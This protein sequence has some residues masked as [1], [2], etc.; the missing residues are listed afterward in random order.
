MYHRILN[1]LIATQNHQ[2]EAFLRGAPPVER[3]SYQFFCHPDVDEVDLKGYGVIVLDF[4]NVK[5]ISLEKIL[6]AKDEQA[7]VVGCFSAD[8]FPTLEEH[9][10]LFDQIWIK[11]FVEEK[12][13]SCFS[14]IMKGLKEQEDSI[15]T[16]KYLDTLID[17]LPDLIWV[18]DAM[19]AHLKVNN[20][21]CRAVNKTKAQI[22]GR[23]HY[24][25]WDLEPDE[26]AQGEYICLESEEIVL[27]KKETCLFDET[28]KCGN[29]LRKFKTYKSPIFDTDGSVIGTVGFAHDV[30]D[31]QNLLIELNILIESL[32]FAV[33]ITDKDR[34]IT[35]V[36]H[37]FI[38]NFLIDRAEV[39]GKPVDSFF[40]ET[41]TF[42]QNKRWIIER[43]K[44]NIL[45]LSENRVL[46]IHEEKLLDIFGKLA[47]YI[48]LFMDITLEYRMLEEKKKLEKAIE[49]IKKLS[50]LLPICSSCKKIRDDKGYWKQIESY[51]S[52]HSE[53]EFSHGI[54]PDCLEKLYGEKNWY[55][56]MKNQTSTNPDN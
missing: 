48:Q 51:I 21:F 19:G 37:R 13:L 45:L 31:L 33:M 32:P 50:G 18:K 40:D 22:E 49:E 15:L 16:Q 9:Y 35:S 5:P 34:T 27:N 2:L 53:A 7:V 38:D 23:G 42:I 28:V 56:K 1:I 47:G 12:V 26:Y 52:E 55:K 14:G 54:C 4:E 39:I 10:Q 6:A 41:R 29:E 25:I 20:S 3:F 43:E 24:Y 17:S 44:E 30:T 36:N 11:P 8:S 46:K